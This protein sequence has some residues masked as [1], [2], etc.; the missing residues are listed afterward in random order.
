MDIPKEDNIGDN[1]KVKVEARNLVKIFG[2]RPEAALEMLEEGR[3][4]KE[5]MEATQQNIAL[6]NVSFEV[7]E[8]EIFVLM[9]LSGCG[10][11]TLLR[12]LNRLVEPTSGEILVDG[13][14]IREMNE[15]ELREF[16]RN[17][18]GM[19]FQGFALL[20]HRTVLDNVAFPLEIQ[21]IP[22]EER[23]Q[24]AEKAISLVGLEGYE[25]SMP[26]ELSGGMQQRVGL[27]RALAGDCDILLM[28]EAFSALDP[29]IRREMQ[30]ELLDL[31]DRVNKTI[32]FVSHDLDEALKL[33]DRIALM[34]DGGIV[35]V[36]TAEDI[37]TNPE[38][39]Y[40]EKFVED[41]DMA[42]VLSAKDVMKRPEPL[43]SVSSGPNNALHL[44]E[45]Y[46]ISSVFAVSKHRIYEGLVLVDDATEAKKSGL[47]LEG[48]I[49][50]DIPSVSPDT[51][52]TE[53]I[54][55]VA[56]SGIPIPVLDDE[57]KI[58]GII[59]KGSV[60][61]ALSRMEV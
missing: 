4:K 12:C 17:K 26:S 11:S 38:T 61:A 9:G 50:R 21:G 40:V 27:A 32:I 57:Q 54:P 23:H 28:D 22:I 24:K 45:E 41:V 14:N 7:Y 53:I 10:K 3:S 1:K 52:V 19:I 47:G 25:N 35:Q 5:I 39:K 42:K 16:R 34:K 13:E 30:D 44:M 51:P 18:I 6:N 8:G 43:V 48:I 20:P 2:P 29:M 58:K 55:L 31:Q 60:L 33:G 37:L 59:I 15:E 49:K 46:G 56:E 36:G